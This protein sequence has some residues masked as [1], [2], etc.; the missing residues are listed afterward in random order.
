MS[1]LLRA[2]LLLLTGLLLNSCMGDEYELRGNYKTQNGA[3]VYD[4]TTRNVVSPVLEMLDMALKYDELTKADSEMDYDL[5]KNLYFSETDIQ[6]HETDTKK[7][8]IFSTRTSKFRMETKEGSD[9]YSFSGNSFGLTIQKGNKED[10]YNLIVNESPVST[11][12][13]SIL[14]SLELSVQTNKKADNNNDPFVYKLT[15]K[16]DYYYSGS[17]FLQRRRT[18]IKFQYTQQATTKRVD[19][20]DFALKEFRFQ[21][22]EIKLTATGKHLGGN[23]GKSI[24]IR[25]NS[26]IEKS[27]IIGI[28]FNSVHETVDLSTFR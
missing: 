6:K 20:P 12:G 16:G 14:A 21:N 17:A 22:G 25:Q 27:D 18:Y 9:V 24:Y 11:H 13:K 28:W 10:E 26:L 4:F 1:T 8:V 3:V 5:L 2:T 7:V 19:I 23:S 15:G